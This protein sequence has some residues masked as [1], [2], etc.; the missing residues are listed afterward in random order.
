MLDTGVDLESDERLR[1]L[2][3]YLDMPTEVVP[4]GLDF[5]RLFLKQTVLDWRYQHSLQRAETASRE[6][7]QKT[8]DYAMAFDLLT[9]LTRVM[10][11][12][13]AIVQ[14]LD[15]FT[16]LFSFGSVAYCPV[17]ADQVQESYNCMLEGASDGV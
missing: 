16:M 17:V 2:G 11:E 10:T 12:E 13:E 8:A 4:V 3:S 9:Q 1:E 15:L 6:A 14:I 7:D 5:F